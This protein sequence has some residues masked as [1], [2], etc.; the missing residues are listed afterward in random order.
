MNFLCHALPYLNDPMM[1]IGTGVPDW[2]SVVDRKIR[3]RSR[4]AASYVDDSDPV[5]SAIARGIVRHHDDDRWF[6]GTEAFVTT[7]LQFAVQ[8]RDQLPGD[9]GF[10]PS[11][12]GHIL[13]EVLLDASW[14]RQQPDF[15]E[16][17]YAEL[18]GAPLEHIQHC[19]NVITG[20]PTDRLVEVLQRFTRSRFLFDYLDQERLLFR[21]NQVMNRVGLSPLPESLLPWLAQAEQHVVRQR[22]MMLSPPGAASP[23][24]L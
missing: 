7:N 23:F 16:R 22:D 20:R 24:P 11:F 21:L 17:Y 18:A 14:L 6:H 9:E 13:I 12:V 19:V 15:G 3:A 4:M 10:R 2:L 5:L 1:A 8:L